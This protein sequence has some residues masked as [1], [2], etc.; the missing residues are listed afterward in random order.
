MG[1]SVGAST[2][3][4]VAVGGSGVGGSAVGGGEVGL[5]ME[6]TVGVKEGVTPAPMLQAWLPRTTARPANNNRTIRT[7]M[8]LLG[9]HGHPRRLLKR[10]AQL[11]NETCL[12]PPVSSLERL[13]H[14]GSRSS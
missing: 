1:V 9:C 13:T 7:F 12:L 8:F 3:A 14:I 10:A 11:F 6:T 4:D 5:E 2:G